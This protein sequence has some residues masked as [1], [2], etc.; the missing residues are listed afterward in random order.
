MNDKRFLQKR[1]FVKFDVLYT[2]LQIFKFGL[3]LLL[4]LTAISIHCNKLF[5]KY[6]KL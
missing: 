4:A 3:M 1:R 2:V 6:D 5:F